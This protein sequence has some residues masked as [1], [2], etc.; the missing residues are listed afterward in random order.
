V[1]AGKITWE[2]EKSGASWKDLEGTGG[3]GKTLG[4]LKDKV[5]GRR[6]N[7]P[8]INICS[9]FGSPPMD[10]LRGGNLSSFLEFLCSQH[11]QKYARDSA[12]ITF[13]TL[14]IFT[15]YSEGIVVGS[16]LICNTLFM[17]RGTRV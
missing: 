11:R 10:S 15:V 4:E 2:L 14:I 8:T 3:S 1:G 9:S 13:F 6:E 17:I 12:C 5:G 7:I 16:N